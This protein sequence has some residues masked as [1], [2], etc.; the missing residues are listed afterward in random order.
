MIIL[1]MQGGGP[2]LSKSWLRNMCTLPNIVLYPKVQKVQQD[3]WS[4]K[5]FLTMFGQ[6]KFGFEKKNLVIF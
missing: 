4:K 1:I 5:Y 3:S 6:A 2:E